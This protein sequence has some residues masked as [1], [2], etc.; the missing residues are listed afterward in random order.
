MVECELAS[1]VHTLLAPDS[2]HY[3]TRPLINIRSGCA[4]IEVSLHLERV[5]ME[6][7]LDHVQRHLAALTHNRL[8]V[9]CKLFQQRDAVRI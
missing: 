4:D 3:Q 6:L 5:V 7:E 1:P 2:V 9:A 8:L